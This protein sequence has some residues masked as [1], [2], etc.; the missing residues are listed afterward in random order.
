MKIVRCLLFAVFFLTRTSSLL[1]AEVD[2]LTIVGLGDS[3]T[4]GTPGFESPLESPP[5]GL[6]NPESQ[7]AYW[8]TQ[9][10]PEW[11]VLNQGIR[12][13][14]SDQ[15]RKRLRF[16]LEQKPQ[17]VIVLAGVN[18]LYQGLPPQWVIENLAAMYSELRLQGVHV[19]ACTILPFNG[20]PLGIELAMKSVNQWILNTAT[21]A[22]FGFCDTGAVV[23]KPG[24]RHLLR[25]T[26]DGLHP[27]IE[28]YRL[29]GQALTVAVEQWI[30]MQKVSPTVRSVKS[31]KTV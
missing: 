6:G 12:G 19:I 28:G 29:M 17:I 1:R 13:Q 24:E 9:A 27:D 25:A 8:M 21:E 14:R 18:D 10:H 15:I 22:G 4:A 26:P 30:Q 23:A 11:R 3:T 20:A 16:A 31:S 5:E 2:I 7:Y